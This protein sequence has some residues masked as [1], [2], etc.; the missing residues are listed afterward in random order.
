MKIADFFVKIGLDGAGDVSKGLGKVSGSLKELF[1][2]SIQTKLTLAGIA[3]GLTGAAFSAGKTG[4][5]LNAFAKG[6]GLSAQELQRWQMASEAFNV[7]GEE[8]TGTIEALQNALSEAKNKGEYNPIFSSMGIDPR[9]MKDAFEFANTLRQRIQTSNVDAAR[10]FSTGLIGENVFQAFRQM[11]DPSKMAPVRK[12]LSDR[13]IQAMQ[14]ISVDFTRFSENLKRSM[15][16]FIVKN[17]PI[18]EKLIK[19]IERLLE[20]FLKWTT[21]ATEKTG[22]VKDVVEGRGI[23]DITVRTSARI[24]QG[25]VDLVS[26]TVK[27]TVLMIANEY[28]ASKIL[29]E[30]DK[31]NEI[32]RPRSSLSGSYKP[33]IVETQQGNTII[34]IDYADF[35]NSNSKAEFASDAKMLATHRAVKGGS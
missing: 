29:N 3:A 2:M 25:M 19:G 23:G 24:G 26:D 34:Q 20:T 10:I 32:I 35:T 8:M 15:E 17:Q 9:E 27:D 5:A 6:F 30:A 18:I 11:G 7:S 28:K 22:I 21:D 31:R 13:E 16:N 33:E 4:A 14:K 12:I 1:S